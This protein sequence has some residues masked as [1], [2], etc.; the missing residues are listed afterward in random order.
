MSTSASASALVLLLAVSRLGAAVP[1]PQD[2]T[3][4]M[5]PSVCMESADMSLCVVSAAAMKARRG[6]TD[7]P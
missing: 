4:S 5:V 1:L 2:G 6:L 7:I 3:T